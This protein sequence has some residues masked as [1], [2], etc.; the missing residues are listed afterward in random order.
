MLTSLLIFSYLWKFQYVAISFFSYNSSHQHLIYFLQGIVFCTLGFTFLLAFF[1]SDQKCFKVLLFVYV[2]TEFP[3]VKIVNI[4][5]DIEHLKVQFSL[6]R[7]QKVQPQVMETILSSS[8][9]VFVPS[10]VIFFSH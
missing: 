5:K 7:Y 10:V 9:T 1:L 2:T 3:H 6:T 8:Y 4:G